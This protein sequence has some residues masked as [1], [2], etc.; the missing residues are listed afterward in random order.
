MRSTIRRQIRVKQVLEMDPAPAGVS[1]MQKNYRTSLAALGV[2][3]VLVLLI[4]CANVANLMTAQAAAR[5]REMALRVSIGAGRWRL[6]QLVLVEA[7]IIGLFASAVGW[8]FAQWSAPFVLARVNPPD[9]PAR[10][11]LAMDWRVLAFA[12]VLTLFVSLLFGVAPAL[13]ASAIRPVEVLKGGDSSHSRARWMRA[14]I[15]LQAAFCFVVLFVAGLFVA[16]FDRLH[17]QPNGFSSERIRQYRYRQ[18][19][20]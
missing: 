11:S 6:G 5:T 18:S 16:T 15:A 2:L 14:L 4:A 19:K 20:E 7:A 1:A 12:A 9:N 13:R 10:L 8:C 3:V 17:G